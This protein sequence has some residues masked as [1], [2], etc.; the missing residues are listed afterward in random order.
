MAKTNSD[1]KRKLKSATSV[2]GLAQIGRAAELTRV[3]FGPAYFPVCQ[4]MCFILPI[5]HNYILSH[6]R[7][8][9]N[10]GRLDSDDLQ[11]VNQLLE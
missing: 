9:A 10:A 2:S 6:L 7:L 8:Q 4:K 11:V 5:C 3:M 1:A